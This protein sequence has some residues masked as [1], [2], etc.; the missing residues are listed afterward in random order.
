MIYDPGRFASPAG[1][2]RGPRYQCQNYM[3]LFGRFCK[4]FKA[5][6]QNNVFADGY[7]LVTVIFEHLLDGTIYATSTERFTDIVG[8]FI[9]IHTY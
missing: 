8:L 4:T 1:D 5:T 9:G 6:S 7:G 2:P 3:G